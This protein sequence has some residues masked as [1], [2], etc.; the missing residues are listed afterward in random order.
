MTNSSSR[1]ISYSSGHWQCT[2][3]Q[4]QQQHTDSSVKGNQSYQRHHQDEVLVTEAERHQQQGQEQQ[5]AQSLHQL[6]QVMQLGMQSAVAGSPLL[7]QQQVM[8]PT[9]PQQ[10]QKHS[11]KHDGD[12]GRRQ[13]P[14]YAAAAWQRAGDDA[15][16]EIRSLAKQ[17]ELSVS[18]N[19]RSSQPVALT[20]TSF[21][22]HLETF[23]MHMGAHNW[24]INKHPEHVL[25]MFPLEE[26]IVLSPDADEPLLQLDP[27]KAYVIGGIV[28]RSV[29]KGLTA[30]FGSRHG[31]TSLRLPVAEYAAQLGLDYS[32]AST[33][34][35][36][37]VSDVVVA[38]I[39]Y[40]RTGDWVHALQQAVPAR[41][42]GRRKEQ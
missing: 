4:Q 7:P 35:V 18:L 38:L 23:A 25:D 5:L 13:V 9:L 1:S 29:C 17:I 31:L 41:K 36:L 10:Q 26:L 16:K 19:R 37:N 32:G 22:S 3:Q 8:Q 40:Q 11:S 39:E 14:A 6:H 28:D 27:Q 24:P 30:G 34:P 15:S 21:T 33:R 2:L 42:R 12:A 20:V